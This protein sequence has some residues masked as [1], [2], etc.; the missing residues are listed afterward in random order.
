[1]KR[2]RV[3][4]DPPRGYICLASLPPCHRQTL[5]R[6]A[7]TAMCHVSYVSHSCAHLVHSFMTNVF[8]S[9][10]ATLFS[11]VISTCSTGLLL[12]HMWRFNRF[13]CL[14]FRKEDAFRWM[15]TCGLT[16]SVFAVRLEHRIP[17]LERNDLKG[18]ISPLSCGSRKFSRRM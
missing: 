10:S 16:V 2:P 5:S 9:P 12:Y 18:T 8:D 15:V 14:L 7:N 11:T 1:M 3:M 4:A 13:R 17:L 6:I